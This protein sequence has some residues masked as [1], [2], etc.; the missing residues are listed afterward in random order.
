MDL[1]AGLQRWEAGPLK[2]SLERLPERKA[3]FETSSGIE[4]RRLYTPLEAASADYLDE[5]GF[6][7]EPPFTRGVQPTM[8]RGRYWTM[9]QYAGFATAEETNRRY[10]YLLQHGQTG[11]SV[12]FDL[13]TQIGYDSDHPLARG[14]VGKVGVAVSSLRDAETLFDGIPLGEVSTSMTIN[15]TAAILLAMYAAVAEG[16]GVKTESLQGTIQNDILKEYAAR[17]TYIFPPRPSMRVVT[18]LFAFCRERMPRFNPISISGYHIREAGATAVQEVAFTLANGIAYVEAALAAG[19]DVDGFAG[20]LSFFFNSHS[21]FLEEVAKFR[22]CRRLWAQIMIERFQAKRPESCMLRFHTQT[23]GCTLTAAQPDNNVVRVAFQALAA[24]LGGTQ[25][26]HTNS[27]DEAL[28]L[29]TEESVRIALRTQQIIAHESGAAD[30]VDP[31][32]GSYCVES[33]TDE[34]E[35]RAR[36]YIDKIDG[37]GGAVAA[38]EAGYMQSEIAES[39]YRHQR[40]VESRDRVVVGVNQFQAAE[41]PPR[42][43][44]R[45]RPEVERRQ[46]GR[47]ASHRRRRSGD[48]IASV[49]SGVKKAAA[50]T[51]NVVFPI[52]EA[53]KAG[54]TLGEIS[55]ALREVFGEYKER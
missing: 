44:L 13:P 12:A 6:P 33:L 23:A 41:K 37:M 25:S 39:A 49:L 35:A 24:V 20:R 8:Y 31:L 1:E 9:R 21:N 19:L 30:T 5:L 26:L 42:R 55:D 48:A 36:E 52:M 7:G 11:L 10:R 14:E 28:A 51:D 15:S 46:R 45:I 47:L 43:L 18:D 40:E 27:R 32:G 38:I 16:H 2:A 53:V 17:G 4:V 29:P 22:A 3:R 50:G 54:A 34:I